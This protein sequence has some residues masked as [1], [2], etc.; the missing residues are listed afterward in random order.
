MKRE[1]RLLSDDGRLS[2][3]EKPRNKRDVRIP[4]TA[5]V[6][7]VVSDHVGWIHSVSPSDWYDACRNRK[8]CC[9]TT[10]QKRTGPSATGPSARS[11]SDK[12]TRKFSELL[13]N[14]PALVPVYALPPLS[15]LSPPL[16]TSMRPPSARSD[17]ITHQYTRGKISYG[18]YPAVSYMKYFPSTPHTTTALDVGVGPFLPTIS[19]WLVTHDS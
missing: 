16:C 5:K 6:T 4:L 19:S 3:E 13:Q 14:V 9:R 12:T 18:T 1:I 11:M 7:F 2:N 15:P 17:R 10:P 8:P